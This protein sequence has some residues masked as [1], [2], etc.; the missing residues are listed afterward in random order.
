MDLF[1]RTVTSDQPVAD[2]DETA[3]VDVH[4]N[5]KSAPPPEPSAGKQT[6]GIA[7]GNVREEPRI[8]GTCDTAAAGLTSAA[9][10]QDAFVITANNASSTAAARAE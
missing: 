10:K 9:E 3:A 8:G 5:K 4:R 7:G 6:R 1:T 2:I